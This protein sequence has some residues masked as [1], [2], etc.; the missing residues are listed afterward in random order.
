MKVKLTL[1]QILEITG[2]TLLGS[3]QY[4]IKGIQG[5]EQAQTGDLAFY[6]NEKYKKYLHESNASVILIPKDTGLMP[7]IGQAFIE[8]D[9]LML[10]SLKF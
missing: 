7:K 6:Y 3:T 5:L 10:H 4:I 8:T 9:N 2:G 1:D